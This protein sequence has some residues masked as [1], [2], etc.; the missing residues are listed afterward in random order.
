MTKIKLSLLMVQV[1]WEPCLTL[2][3]HYLLSFKPNYI[4]ILWKNEETTANPD[5]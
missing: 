4:A 1:A 3:T 2:K 5:V